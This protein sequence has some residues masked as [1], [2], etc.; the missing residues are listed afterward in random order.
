[1]LLTIILILAYISLSVHPLD[2][3]VCTIPV[4]GLIAY[5]TME[6]KTYQNDPK[7]GTGRMPTALFLKF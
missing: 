1:M 7:R 3:V 4:I 6:D 5:L 2:L